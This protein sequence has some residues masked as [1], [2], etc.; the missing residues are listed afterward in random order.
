MTASRPQFR[1]ISGEFQD[2]KTLAC[3]LKSAN[4]ASRSLIMRFQFALAACIIAGAAMPAAAF[5]SYISMPGPDREIHPAGVTDAVI[6]TKEQTDGQLGMV[7]LDNPVGA[8]PGP[9]IVN[10]KAADYFFVIDGTYEF[11]LGD[12]VVDAGPGTLLAAD[13]GTPHGYIT[14]TPG[15]ILTIFAP[16]GYEHFFIDWDKEQPTPGPDLGKIEEKYGV[17][18][19]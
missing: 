8:G 2:T 7:I 6:A 17:T 1:K 9:A 12:K 10:S 4:P 13:K 5:Q 11:H 16:G 3:S 18:R 14:K 19:P 15:H